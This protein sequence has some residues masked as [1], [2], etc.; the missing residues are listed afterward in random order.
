MI[1]I[2]K[3]DDISSLPLS[4]RSLNALRRSGLH[5]VSDLL[6]YVQK[7]KC[8]TLPYVG[9]KCAAEIKNC[10]NN[11]LSSTTDYCLADAKQ[12]S[13]KDTQITTDI[14]IDALPLSVHTKY[15]LRRA[16][17]RFASQLQDISLY[18]FLSLNNI[19]K[20]TAEAAMKEIREFQQFVSEQ[21]ENDLSAG[22]DY[23]L[24]IVD[25][26]FQTF[27]KTKKIWLNEIISVHDLYPSVPYDLFLQKLYDRAFVRN[28]TKEFIMQELHDFGNKLLKKILVQRLPEHLKNTEILKSVFDE[29]KKSGKITEEKNMFCTVLP[30]ATEYI[31]TLPDGRNK[32]MLLQRFQGA[33]L[34]EIGIAFGITRER[35][36]QIIRKEFT[37]HPCLREDKYIYIYE[38]YAFTKHDF[39]LAFSE[40]IETY[41]Y[42]EIV[43]KTSKEQKQKVNDVFLQ[44]EAVPDWA[45]KAVCRTI[46][47]NYVFLEN[48][49]MQK[50]RDNLVKY[51]VKT[52]CRKLT[53]YDVFLNIYQEVL[54]KLDCLNNPKLMLT[55]RYEN[56]LRSEMYVLWN[57]GSRFRYYDI[58]GKNYE[59][60]FSTL[61]LEQYENMKISTKEIFMKHLDLM[62]QYDIRDEYE[63]HN[64]L[65]KVWPAQKRQIVFHKMP[66][67]QIEN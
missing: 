60:L 24:K 1:Y 38:H 39:L 49:W 37:N 36:R 50:S 45:K 47:Q 14:L 11:I 35:V 53:K 48:S 34:R 32:E 13:K 61:G 18:D 59:S 2:F 65:R 20:K 4:T 62:K 19:G 28:T 26:L 12:M 67:I 16:N 29:L 64:L 6:V 63:L 42:L 21:K 5:T 9:K 15:C 41:I 31:K 46:C 30:T 40:R 44:D 52:R 51:T 22:F 3:D 58:A 66:V 10:I 17:V 54:R 43:C 33:T 55:S 8:L 56:R 7:D 25:E 27:G 57:M 23:G